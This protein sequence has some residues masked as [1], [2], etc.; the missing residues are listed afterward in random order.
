MEKEV[1]T[2][3]LGLSESV[4]SKYELSKSDAVAVHESACIGVQELS[5]TVQWPARSLSLR[6]RKTFE[7]VLAMR[8]IGFRMIFEMQLLGTEKT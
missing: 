7:H 1:K 6:R 4:G 5:I 3:A 8:Q 2:T